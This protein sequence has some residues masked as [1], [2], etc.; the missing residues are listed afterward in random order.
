MQED[1]YA[2]LKYRVLEQLDVSI[3]EYFYL[4]MVHQL[5]HN[6][7]CTKSVEEAAKHMRITS[8]GL[9]KMRTRLIDAGYLRR[10]IKGHLKTT[11]K[12]F[13][14]VT[15]N[16]GVN[17]VRRG[18]NKVP[19]GGEQS[20]YKNNNRMTENTGASASEVLNRLY[21]PKPT[22]LPRYVVDE[23]A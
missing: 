3:A 14:I 20:S 1:L 22:V 7:W 4:D 13:D 23:R 21:K 15:A 2:L 5:S 18:V 9:Q 6:R 19:P 8:R 11:D 12:Y 17:K 16:R 10:N